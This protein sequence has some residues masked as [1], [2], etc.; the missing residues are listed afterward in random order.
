MAIQ[1]YRRRWNESRGDAFFSWGP[2][3]YYFEVGEDGWP[4]RQI[5]V[6]D[7]GPTLRYGPGHEEDEFGLLGQAPLDQLEDWQPWAISESEFAQAWQDIP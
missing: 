6:Y 1:Y 7:S 3:T 2:A 5:E 4:T